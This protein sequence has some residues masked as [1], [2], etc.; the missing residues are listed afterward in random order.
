MWSFFTSA[1]NVALGFIFK[2]GT[3]KFVVFGALSL[4]LAPL[5]SLLMGL[6]DSTGLNGI[7]SLVGQLPSDIL[8]YMGVFRLDV[9]LP[10]LIAAMLTRFFIRR[11]PVVG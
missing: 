2:L 10:M 3:I 11:L 1:I 5:M 7:P 4:L 6:I 8:F 9:G